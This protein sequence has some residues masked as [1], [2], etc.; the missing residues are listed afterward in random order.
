MSEAGKQKPIDLTKRDRH[1]PAPIENMIV[2]FNYE[3]VG[4][5]DKSTFDEA[6]RQIRSEQEV[7]KWLNFLSRMPNLV[8]KVGIHLLFLFYGLDTVEKACLADELYMSRPVR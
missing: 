2:K 7:I 5:Y 4:N 8:Q 6:V 1:I 3:T